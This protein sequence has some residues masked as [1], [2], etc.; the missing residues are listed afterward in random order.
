M[1]GPSPGPDPEDS[2][3]DDDA[4]P[5]EDDEFSFD[6]REEPEPAQSSPPPKVASQRE[7]LGGSLP[8][9]QSQELHADG[10]SS[11]GGGAS[12]G[13][14]G[15]SA[16]ASG[17]ASVQSSP[18]GA[19]ALNAA[20]AH[21][22]AVAQEISWIQENFSRANA[23]MMS[24]GND[25]MTKTLKSLERDL[26]HLQ[27]DRD[28]ANARAQRLASEKDELVRAHAR[29]EADLRATRQVLDETR[30]R[31]SHREMDLQLLRGGAATNNVGEPAKWEAGDEHLELQESPVNE[32]GEPHSP[33]SE[34][35]QLASPVMNSLA[36]Q[37]AGLS[38]VKPRAAMSKKQALAVLRATQL[39]LVQEKKRR[40]RLE[41]RLQKDHDRLQRLVALA[42]RQREDIKTIQSS[43]EAP[44]EQTRRAPNEGAAQRTAEPATR[45]GPLPP[46]PSPGAPGADG[47][48]SMPASPSCPTFVGH[49]AGGPRSGA[50]TPPRSGSS[51]GAPIQRL[52][53]VPRLPP[54]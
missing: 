1:S 3:E 10:A 4:S 6:E 17:S 34:D 52:N 19:L 20:R 40:E 16:G 54:V 11:G 27:V 31:L 33:P 5:Y 26:K 46:P 51:F 29:L 13:A 2:F 22:V 30:R 18:E 36:H 35:D 42:R 50:A 49:A 45:K 32:S 38:A 48:R 12:G 37:L 9:A 25:A 53:S 47:I 41:K 28:C 15:G 23:V 7:R 43:K 14:S 24:P 21:L 39:E 44:A 8:L